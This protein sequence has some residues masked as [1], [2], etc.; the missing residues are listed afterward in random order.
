MRAPASRYSS[1][2]PAQVK[3]PVSKIAHLSAP[4]KGLSLSSKLTP[5]DA[6]T[7]SILVN[8]NVEEDRITAR[9][10]TKK[11]ATMTGAQAVWG[12]VPFYGTPQRMLGAT[13]NTLCDMQT[14]AVAQGG[15]HGNDWSWTSFANLGQQKF[16]VM[17]NGADGVWSWGGALVPSADP[18]PVPVLSLTNANPAVI[19]VGAPDIGKLQNGMT[20][21]IAGATG[22]GMTAAN[23]A[24]VIQGVASPANSYQLVGVNT[25][26]GS[27]PQTTGVT[28][29]APPLQPMTKEIVTAPTSD[30]W[31]VTDQF[32]IVLS[33]M[34]RLWFAD[35]SNLAV[36]YLPLQQKSGEVKVI[37]LNAVFKKGGTIRAMYTWTVEGGMGLNDQLA[38]FTS[39]GECA[40]YGGTDPD[41]DFQLQ[42]VFRFNPPLSK[43]CVINYGG[44]LYVLISTGLMPLTTLMRAEDPKLGKSD[45]DMLTTF[46]IE[47]RRFADRQ[48]WQ[49]FFNPSTGRMIANIPQ[50]ADNR[51]RQL[52]RNMAKQVWA[53][54]QGMP[55]RC[56]GWLDPYVYFGDDHGNVYRMA[57]EYLNDNGDPIRIDVQMAWSDY[58]SAGLKAFRMLKTYMITDGA[59]R[60]RVDI[61]VNYDATPPENE[62]ENV[63]TFAIGSDWDTADWDDGDGL[64]ASWAPGPQPFAMWN[65]VGRQGHVGA[66]RLTALIKDCTFAITGWDVIYEEG[67]ALG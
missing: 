8:M 52:V 60:P 37:P 39:S 32:N 33:H 36:F 2:K 42:G 59:P 29:D 41:T 28:V 7:A 65:G 12:L 57:P 62:P 48:G 10:G 53:E 67:A 51:Y 23:G 24:H 27:A 55:A 31:I 18:G 19:T 64:G 17:V 1:P 56:W 35:T 13:N 3:R 54:Y 49:A 5:S 66:P 58:K 45:Q 26:A 61:K 46:L 9:S 16:T 34:N 30:P 38:I 40:I 47:A 6:L 15:F 44:D 22:T 21:T 63:T 43:H 25:S 14:G 50:G 20:V 4:L 11:L